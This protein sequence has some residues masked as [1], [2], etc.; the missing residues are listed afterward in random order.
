VYVQIFFIKQ[1]LVKLFSVL[2]Y[3]DTDRKFRVPGLSERKYC[4]GA[5]DRHGAS[6]GAGREAGV[7]Q[8]QPGEDIQSQAHGCEN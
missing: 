3:F 1:I 6:G 2:F 8:G 5:A 4:R 7:L